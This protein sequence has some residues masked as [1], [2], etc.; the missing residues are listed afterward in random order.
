ML[1]VTTSIKEANKIAKDWEQNTVFNLINVDGE[2]TIKVTNTEM[3]LHTFWSLDKYKARLEQIREAYNSQSLEGDGGD[4]IASLFFDPDDTW[5]QEKD[6]RSRRGSFMLDGPGADLGQILAQVAASEDEG[7][8]AVDRLNGL[9]HSN[10]VL[11]KQGS[12]KVRS[13]FSFFLLSFT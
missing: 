4:E 11:R 7:P 10:V 2:P 3:K 1:A 12:S 5:R 8:T 6:D 9:S 13:R